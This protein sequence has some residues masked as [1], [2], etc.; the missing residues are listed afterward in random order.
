MS[1]VSQ[2]ISPV[3]LILSSRFN[4]NIALPLPQRLRILTPIKLSYSVDPQA[5]QNRAPCALICRQ[6]PQATGAPVCGAHG[7]L[8]VTFNGWPQPGIAIPSIAAIPA[9]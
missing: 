2:T 3:K 9:A 4:P 7:T 8:T 6:R 5:E 1:K